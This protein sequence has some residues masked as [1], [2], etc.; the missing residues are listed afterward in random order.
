MP[1]TNAENS[2][3]ISYYGATELRDI[4]FILESHFRWHLFVDIK[5]VDILSAPLKVVHEL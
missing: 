3:F 4:K 2:T 1:A 5:E